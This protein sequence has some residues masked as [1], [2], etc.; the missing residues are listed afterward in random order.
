MVVIIH[1]LSPGLIHGTG[2]RADDVDRLL[3]MLLNDETIKE[4]EIQPLREAPDRQQQ[5]IGSRRLGDPR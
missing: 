4:I 5:A 1:I 2:R 3:R